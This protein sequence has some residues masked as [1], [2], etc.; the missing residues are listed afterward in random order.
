METVLKTVQR[1]KVF[2]Q[3]L[4]QLATRLVEARSGSLIVVNRGGNACSQVILADPGSAAGFFPMH[5]L[6]DMLVR[7][8]RPLGQRNLRF[9]V[10]SLGLNLGAMAARSFLG[11]PLFSRG[12]MYG[13]LCFVEK[14]GAEGF[15]LADE[16]L[17]ENFA[18]LAVRAIEEAPAIEALRRD[19][20]AFRSV[21]ASAGAA[22]V[23]N[24]ARE[25]ILWNDGA[26]E[27][28]GYSREE[29]L[30]RRVEDILVP[31]AEKAEWRRRY[32]GE[33][34]RDL[35]TGM[36]VQYVTTRR[37]KSGGTMPVTVTLHP[38]RHGAAGV[39]A[40]VASNLTAA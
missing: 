25:I 6:L 30:G 11:V 14:A 31:E 35:R 21:A 39:K 36:S 26:S 27:L 17:A 18:R 8:A 1:E 10:S 3:E 4:V 34:A 33:I 37:H 20:D 13:N 38:I 19:L 9:D 2:F 5:V 12:G 24:S 29:A 32:V 7:S 40:V 16:R 15:S 23:L 22:I 28:F